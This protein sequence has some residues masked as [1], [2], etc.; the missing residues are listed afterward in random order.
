M[1]SFYIS[2]SPRLST[3]HMALS[4]PRPEYMRTVMS[5]LMTVPITCFIFPAIPSPSLDSTS[6]LPSQ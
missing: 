6:M 1:F 5:M 2:F 4:V 3:G